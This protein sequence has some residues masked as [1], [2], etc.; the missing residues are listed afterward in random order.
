MRIL[1]MPEVI[2]RR[3][4]V[5]PTKEEIEVQERLA[6]EKRPMFGYGTGAKATPVEQKVPEK[7]SD[8][9]KEVVEWLEPSE[10]TDS[11]GQLSNKPLQ[12]GM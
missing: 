8:V 12:H 10:D 2:K 3:L 1:I 5:K 9:P 6:K 7:P 4:D 11:Q